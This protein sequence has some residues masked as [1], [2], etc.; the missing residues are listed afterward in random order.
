[1]IF[2]ILMCKFHV[3][4]GLKYINICRQ[5]ASLPLLALYL[6][7]CFLVMLLL[8]ILFKNAVPTTLCYF[9]ASSLSIV[10]MTKYIFIQSN[11]LLRV[12]ANVLIFTLEQ[13]AVETLWHGN[14]THSTYHLL[15]HS[16]IYMFFIFFLLLV[17]HKLHN[18]Q[19]VLPL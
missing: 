12:K 17:K 9:R 4:I 11:R 13:Q 14:L 15:I 16:Y 1:M 8:I 7:F 6:C 19:G 5:H 18:Q 2:V 3:F 10:R